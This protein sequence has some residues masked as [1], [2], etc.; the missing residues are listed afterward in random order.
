M[1]A[2]NGYGYGQCDWCRQPGELDRHP[3]GKYACLSCQEHPEWH[4]HGDEW[5]YELWLA[6]RGLTIDGWKT[7]WRTEP[8]PL[9]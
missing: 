1:P 2:P 6:E 8:S 9:P 3:S 4:G 7:G 5:A